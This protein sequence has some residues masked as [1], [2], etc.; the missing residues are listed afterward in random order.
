[1]TEPVLKYVISRSIYEASVTRK[2]HPCLVVSYYSESGDVFK[3]WLFQ[4]NSIREWW[5]PRSSQPP[6]RTMNDAANLASRG[7]VLPT[8]AVYIRREGRWPTVVG[9]EVG[10]FPESFAEFM[11]EVKEVFGEVEIIKVIA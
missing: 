4:G 8:S 11:R 2:G 3:E 5:E 7:A 1:M 6:P 9:T 10:K